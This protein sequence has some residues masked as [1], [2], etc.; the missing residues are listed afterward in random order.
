MPLSLP[1]TDPLRGLTHAEAKRRLA[2]DGRNE[3]PATHSRTAVHIILDV[4]R[5][6]MFLLLIATSALYFWLGDPAEATLLLCS[7]L[8]I[9]GISFYQEHKAE[10]A[11][12]A[13]RELASPHALVLRQGKKQRID[14]RDLVQGDI[15]FLTEGDRVSADS[16][17][18]EQTNLGVDESL[19]TGESVPVNKTNWNKIQSILRPGGD[20][21]AFVYAGTLVIRGHALAQVLRIGMA[22]EMGQIGKALSLMKEEETNIQHQ[23]KHIITLFALIGGFLCLLVVLA[24]G[25]RNDWAHGLL[26]GL[27]L[28]MA[29]LPE[30]FPVVLTI[31]LAVGAWRIS[32]R[33]VLTRRAPAI[34]ALGAITTLCA[35]KTGTITQNNMTVEWIT[36]RGDWQN[37]TAP[38]SE[39]PTHIRETLHSALAAIPRESADPMEHAIE[40]TAVAFGANG[41]RE[42]STL[43]KEYPLT[44]KLLAMTHVW[45]APDNSY[46][47]AC[48]GSPEAVA[49]LCELDA[50]TREHLHADI[51]RMTTKGLRVIAVAKGAWSQ[52]A[53]PQDQTA[54]PFQF[55]GLIGLM[56]PIRPEMPRA[57]KECRTAG[58]RVLIITG[59][60][61][62]TA[63]HIARQI[64]LDTKQTILTGAEIDAMDDVTLRQRLKKTQVIARALPEQKTRIVE[65][66]KANGEI[67]AMTG[68]GIN[69]A[70][71][72]KAAHV[73]I[74]M[75]GRGTDVAR[76]AADL[77]LLD[78]NFASIVAAIRAGRGLY[79]NLKKAM[80]FL[81]SVHIPIAGISLIPA[82]LN[83]PLVLLPAQIVFLEFII[84]PACSVVYEMEKEEAD[85]MQRKPRTLSAK[86]FSRRILLSGLIQGLG[87]LAVVTGVYFFGLAR[88]LSTDALRALC[89]ATLVLGNLILIFA[90]RSR[91]QFIISTIQRANPAAWYIVLGAI[92]VLVLTLTVPFL[93]SLFHFTA[94]R[95]EDLT[96]IVL[97]GLLMLMIAESVKLP[98]RKKEPLK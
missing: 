42:A 86:L 13:L 53:L 24:F 73:G 50:I 74:A 8:V 91:T 51:E 48:K 47:I 14:S 93:Q 37:A 23:T 79:D 45:Q 68:D 35:D 27:A 95:L 15:L 32:Q 65:A 56:D 31:F 80:G 60:Y 75:G 17:L 38:A 33:R 88:G 67:V 81:F 19:L 76:E 26:A 43:V 87:V 36:A 44:S 55:L 11:L 96:T 10:R 52:E 83:L 7:I 72:L 3:L 30:E 25:F 39:T 9:I 70:P 66:L 59:D 71:A 46:D 1:I 85:V 61:P 40:Q 62:G 18:I 4:I 28:A 34:E 6:P 21:S 22:T 90:N 58:I 12:D 97:A 82:L 78:D 49:D 63:L 16:A 77:I 84:D 94:L 5:A 92:A 29:I 20:Q 54:I 41:F 57:I 98:Y 2:R 69:D 89:F 64:G